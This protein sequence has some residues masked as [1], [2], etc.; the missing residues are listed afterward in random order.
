MSLISIWVIFRSTDILAVPRPELP[1]CPDSPFQVEHHGR[2]LRLLISTW[3][4]LHIAIKLARSYDFDAVA[5][6]RLLQWCADSSSWPDKSRN[7]FSP[8]ACSVDTLRG[9]A[10]GHQFSAILFFLLSVGCKTAHS[11]LSIMHCE[12]KC[13]ACR[14]VTCQ[15]TFL[16]VRFGVVLFTAHLNHP[17]WRFQAFSSN[18]IILSY[19]ET[20]S[21]LGLRSSGRRCWIGFLRRRVMNRVTCGPTSRAKRT[22]VH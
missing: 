1:D 10:R 20:R 6:H 3:K 13:F 16:E 15:W 22:S 14:R 8:A 17:R 12:E 11:C 7:I 21:G 19:F 9:T 2:V 18:R 5:L 4:T